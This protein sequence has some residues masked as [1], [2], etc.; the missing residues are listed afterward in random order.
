DT[1]NP[2][3]DKFPSEEKAERGIVA[4]LFH[5]PDKLPVILRNLTPDDF[6]TAFNRRVFET[7]ILRLNKRQSVTTASLGG[8]FS[9]EETG[10]IEK[11]KIENAALPF[12]DERLN[13]YIKVLTRFKKQKDKKSPADMSNTEAMEYA[14][15]LKREKFAKTY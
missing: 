11:I 8:E 7:L 3:A 14:E 13:D 1:I 5:S 10:R 4:F 6:P 9:P 15:K 12:T 2:D